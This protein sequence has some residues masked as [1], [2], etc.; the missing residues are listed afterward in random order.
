MA[1]KVAVVGSGPAGF[2]AAEALLGAGRP[3]EVDLLE[4]LPVP[5][6][7][8]RYGVAPDHPKL[9]AVATEF[10]RIAGLPGFAWHG[11]VEVGRDVGIAELRELY[12]AVIVACG[13]D[14]EQTLGIPGEDLPGVHGARAFVGWYNGHPDFADRDY[15]LS[16][17]DACIVGHG[18]VA[19]DIC[20]ILAKPLAELASTDISRAALAT[21]AGRGLRRIHLIGRRGPVQASF[22]PRELREL[23]TLDGWQVYAPDLQDG[24]LVDPG[25]FEPG[26]F[27]PGSVDLGGLDAASATRVRKNLETLAR[28]QAPPPAGARVIVLH[29]LLAPTQ[30]EGDA[31]VT[32]LRVEHQHLVGDPPRAVGAGVFAH[33][34]CQAVFRSIGYRGRPIAGL[35]WDARRGVLPNRDGRLLDEAGDALP[36][37][38]ASGWIKRGANGIIGTNRADSIA[39]VASLL[40]DFGGTLPAVDGRAGLLARLQQRGCRTVDF[41]G[42]ARIGERERLRGAAIGARACKFL[43]IDEMLAAVDALQAGHGSLPG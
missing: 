12:H 4:R 43:K 29:F 38:Y 20:R 18:N 5:F 22:T 11:N 28:W 13:C 24:G 8:V 30:L 16:C 39:T 23:E 27:E 36:G 14:D 33:I 35:P 9:K 32:G 26:S 31:A 7:L 1:L 42:W 15:D 17:E 21:L 37:L 40:A 3:I 25:S 41:A 34:P 2:Y 10:E 6:G 19:I